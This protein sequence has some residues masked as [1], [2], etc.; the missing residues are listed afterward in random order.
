[1]LVVLLKCSKN[2]FNQGLFESAQ[3]HSQEP[4]SVKPREGENRKAKANPRVWLL[5]ADPDFLDG[6]QSLVKLSY[7]WVAQPGMAAKVFLAA[8][9]GSGG[10]PFAAQPFQFVFEHLNLG[11]KGGV[12]QAQV[13]RGLETGL[14]D[15]GQSGQ[16]ADQVPKGVEGHHETSQGAEKTCV[17]ILHGLVDTRVQKR[18]SCPLELNKMGGR[19]RQNGGLSGSRPARV[20]F[21]NPLQNRL[22]YIYCGAWQSTRTAK[23]GGPPPDVPARL[24]QTQRKA[25]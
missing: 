5:L 2:I 14:E 17:T 6:R 7:G 23:T 4:S 15:C 19:A 9:D 25:A 12:L 8:I 24:S 11:T 3:Y 10:M 21:K 20:N 16:A 22:G 18:P 13:G 1:M